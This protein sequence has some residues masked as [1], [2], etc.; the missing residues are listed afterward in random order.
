[1]GLGDHQKCLPTKAFCEPALPH[2][3]T[4][5]LVLQPVVVWMN[6]N[7][8]HI[9]MSLCSSAI[10]I[11]QTS[12]AHVLLSLLCCDQLQHCNCSYLLA[13]E[14]V[15]TNRQDHKLCNFLLCQSLYTNEAI[16][17]P[18]YNPSTWDTN[19]WADICFNYAVQNLQT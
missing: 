15:F 14:E 6:Q 3:Q 7:F 10:S 8:D 9:G 11:S 4:T 19:F 5:L 13:K 16:T 1:M 2:P 18:A 12:I 17:W